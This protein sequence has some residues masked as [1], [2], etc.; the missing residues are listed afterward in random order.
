MDVNMTLSNMQAESFQI[1]E[2]RN[3]KGWEL[4]LGNT[5]MFLIGIK[6]IESPWLKKKSEFEMDLTFPIFLVVMKSV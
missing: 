5:K 1:H 3:I 2:L 6:K 4:N